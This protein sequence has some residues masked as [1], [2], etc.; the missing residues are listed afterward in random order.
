M[1]SWNGN[2]DVT[3][4]QYVILVKKKPFLFPFY[5]SPDNFTT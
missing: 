2:I 4:S 5:E 3:I 1:F